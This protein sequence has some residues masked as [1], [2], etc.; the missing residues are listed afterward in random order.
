MGTSGRVCE[1]D[2]EPSSYANCQILKVFHTEEVSKVFCCTG[3][4]WGNLKIQETPWNTQTK[5]EDNNKLS[6]TDKDWEGSDLIYL[7][8]DRDRWPVDVNPET[9]LRLP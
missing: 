7:A 6:F 3:F 1:Y 2:N 5:L 4:L 9:K 8:Q